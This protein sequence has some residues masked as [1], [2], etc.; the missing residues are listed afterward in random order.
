MMGW[1]MPP[2]LDW[3]VTAETSMVIFSVTSP[4]EC[5]CGRDVDIHAHVEI[6]ELR[7]HERVDA[8][9]ADARLE[10]SGRDRHAV[11]DLERGFL[12]VESANLRIL[13]EFGVAVI[14]DRRQVGGGNRN[15]EIRGV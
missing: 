1:L 4:L 8:H 13:N 3:P 15:L 7:I 12:P 6:L 2:M 9:A 5:T 11:A 14:H 10:R